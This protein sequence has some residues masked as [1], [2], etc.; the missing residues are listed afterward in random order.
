MIF[1]T[2]MAISPLPGTFDQN[3]RTAPLLN[4]TQLGCASSTDS[5]FST[6]LQPAKTGDLPSGYLLHS[7][8][9]PPFLI[10]KP[11]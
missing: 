1:A 4:G 7:H 11:R 6:L 8:G 10:G 3:Q 2:A 5:S 9:K